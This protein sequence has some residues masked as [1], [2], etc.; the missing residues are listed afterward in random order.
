MQL[1]L[2]AYIAFS[3]LVFLF[4]I[5]MDLSGIARNRS[6][7]RWRT[8]RGYNPK[9]LVI[10]PCKGKEPGLYENLTAAKSQ[11]YRNF[12]L[13]AVVDRDDAA[14]AVV[15]RAGVMRMQ[16]DFECRRC[17]D[18]VRRIAS[19]IRANA[20]YEV[21]AILDS[22]E[23][24]DSGWLGRLVAPLADGRVGISV[25]FPAFKPAD[26]GFWS[27]TKQVWGFVGQSLLESRRTR[28]AAGGSMAFRKELLD[29]RSFGFFA[30]SRYSISDDISLNLIVRRKGLQVAYNRHHHPVTRVREN[31]ASFF[32]WANRQTALAIFANR[33]TF[34]FGIGYYSAEILVFLTGIV[35]AVAVSPLML[36]LLLHALS[37]SMKNMAR[38]REASVEIVAITLMMPFLYLYNLLV[39]NGM[40]SITWRGITYRLS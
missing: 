15:K 34:Y 38:S 31:A 33:K 26:S 40:R 12:G 1:L 25:M 22:D 35:G 28:F 10:V 8:R 27:K 30:D 24:V 23:K 3:A 7:E 11:K 2:S 5:S 18:K 4:L 19:A 29:K 39:A 21:Y 17:S 37:S 9:T 32:E 16:P 6:E 13:I 14:S 20:G 36:V